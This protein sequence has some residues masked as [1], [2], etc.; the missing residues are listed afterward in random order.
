MFMEQSLY[1]LLQTYFFLNGQV[2]GNSCQPE[3]SLSMFPE[4]QKPTT[5]PKGINP[6]LFRHL[7]TVG[8]HFIFLFFF[9]P[10]AGK[11]NVK[12]I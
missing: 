12:I 6:V 10:I 7:I 5:G 11:C 4:N 3:T 2:P 1:L 8:C 9:C